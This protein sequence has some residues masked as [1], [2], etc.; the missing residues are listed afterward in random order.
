MSK[1]KSK[2]ALHREMIEKYHSQ[3]NKYNTLL[4]EIELGVA[5]VKDIKVKKNFPSF[6]SIIPKDYCQSKGEELVE[7]ALIERKIQYLKEVQ[8]KGCINKL[9][10]RPLRFDFFIESISTCIE[11]DGEQ[12]YRQVM[13]FDGNDNGKAFKK[14]KK[15]DHIK[16]SYCKAHGIKLI[17]IKYTQISHI[18]EIINKIYN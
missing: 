17:R 3:N 6:K 5:N 7:L 18:D 11:F 16:D 8:F 9:T 15:L 2:K 1:K 4:K 14:R 13:T 10:R 12:H